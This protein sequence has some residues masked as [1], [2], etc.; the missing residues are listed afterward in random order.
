M[1][2]APFAFSDAGFFAAKNRV[3]SG[4]PSLG[5]FS[6]KKK[7][8]GPARIFIVPFTCRKLGEKKVVP[9]LN[10]DVGGSEETPHRRTDL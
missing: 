1:S 10:K 8:I 6:A 9:L 5:T 3:G 7:L 2:A 4:R